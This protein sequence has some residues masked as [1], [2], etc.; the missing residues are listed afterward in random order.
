VRSDYRA[1]RSD[2]E[3][4]PVFRAG[5]KYLL[6]GSPAAEHAENVVEPGQSIA[7]HVTG[8]AIA[9]PPFAE[10]HQDVAETDVTVPVDILNAGWST[11]TL[12]KREEKG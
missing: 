10:H 12:H 9:W 11:A 8:A 2:R 6:A 7:V 3:E 4:R 5:N 1:S